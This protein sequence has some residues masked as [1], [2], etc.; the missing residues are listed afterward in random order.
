MEGKLLKAVSRAESGKRGSRRVR[1]TGMIPINMYGRG[2]ANMSLQVD[3]DELNRLVRAGQKMV[4]IEVDGAEN[5][6]IFKEVQFDAL[7]G[8]ILHADFARVIPRIF[9]TNPLNR[10]VYDPFGKFQAEKICG[11]RR[12][13]NDHHPKLIFSR[14]CPNI[15]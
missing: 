10:V 2:T 3:A 11:H 9:K 8:N 7:S 14:M 1:A 15:F 13:N 12:E 5:R 6:G 4:S